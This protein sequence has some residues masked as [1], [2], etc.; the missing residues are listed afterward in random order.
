MKNSILCGALASAVLMP[1]ASHAAPAPQ[2]DQT[3]K[4]IVQQWIAEL[5]DSIGI[6][7]QSRNNPCYSVVD[8]RKKG[9]GL[10]SITVQGRDFEAASMYPST[11]RRWSFEKQGYVLKTYGN[12][13]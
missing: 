8:C 7:D 11:D 2:Q 9:Q 12:K 6:S 4:P 3:Q 1:V 13:N 5:S 10:S